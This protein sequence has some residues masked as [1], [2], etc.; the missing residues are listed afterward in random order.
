VDFNVQIDLNTSHSGQ[1]A[2]ENTYVDPRV[3]GRY[4][5]RDPELN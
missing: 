4:R 1:S 2:V 5:K 3:A